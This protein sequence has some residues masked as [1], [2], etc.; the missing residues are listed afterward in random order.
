ML[1][2]VNWIAVVVAIVLMEALGYLWYAVLFSKAWV[3]ALGHAPSTSGQA[4]SQALGVV[5]TVVIVVGLA[6]LLG[7]LGARGLGATLGAA[8][9][10]WFFFDFTTMA[11]DYLYVGQSTTLVAINMGYQLASYALAGVIFGA[12]R[13]RRVV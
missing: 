1:K 13:P 8:L 11:I 7:R 12:I 3:A 4:M 9:A 10:A 2:G 5:N 6:W